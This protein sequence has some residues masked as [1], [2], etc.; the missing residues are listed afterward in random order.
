MRNSHVNFMFNALNNHFADIMRNDMYDIY[1][2]NSR[3]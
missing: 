1:V 2:A 3:A